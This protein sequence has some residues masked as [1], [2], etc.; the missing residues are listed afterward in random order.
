M[1]VLDK[2]AKT[3]Y[4]L[5]LYQQM[6]TH[7]VSGRYSAGQML[8]GARALAAELGISRNTV[9]SAYAQLAAEGYIT[10][11]VGIGF[12]VLKLPKL[13][14]TRAAPQP[15]TRKQVDQE[16]P[17]RYDLYYGDLP[18]KDFPYAL[19]RRHT[20]EVLAEEHRSVVNRWPGN[21]GDE[22]LRRVLADYLFQSRAMIERACSWRPMA[23]R[24]VP[25]RWMSRGLWLRGC[26]RVRLSAPY[27]LPRRTSSL[28]A[29]LCPLPD[30]MSCSTGHMHS[31]PS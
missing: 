12:Q 1:I 23:L 21:L 9:D 27:T 13:L 10:P 22:E 30:G 25:C 20:T 7:M 2:G 5:P 4:Y 19:W 29:P 8:P 11:V 18:Q 26:R 14:G 17:V 15:V 31:R 24:S 16:P 28:W 6:L 3:P